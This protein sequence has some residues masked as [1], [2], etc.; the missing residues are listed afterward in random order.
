MT[1]KVVSSP[2]TINERIGILAL[3]GSY[4]LHAQMLER[5][6]RPTTLIR[7]AEQFDDIS[8]LIVPGGE[9]TVMS[10]LSRELGIFDRIRNEAANGLPLFGTC[11]GAILLGQGDDDPP[12]LGVAPVTLERNAYGRQVDS[13]E[14]SMVLSPAVGDDKPFLGIFIRA[15]RIVLPTTAPEDREY[16]ILGSEGDQVVLLRF[17]NILLSTFHPELTEDPKI[18]R[19]FL[20]MIEEY[21]KQRFR[22]ETAV[23]R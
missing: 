6:G 8:G 14:K 7:R 18:H 17:R 12:R 9:S 4:P 2:S 21:Q 19:Y 1:S 20:K 10:K 11:A 16:E 22:E 23:R 5:I 15:P 13:F 3:Q